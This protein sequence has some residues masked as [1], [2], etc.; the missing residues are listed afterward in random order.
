MKLER[1]RIALRLPT[2]YLE[3]LDE[4][5]R[6]H[7]Q[8]RTEVI[9]EALMHLVK[10]IQHDTYCDDFLATLRDRSSTKSN[11][12]V[13]NIRLPK[14]YLDYLKLNLYNITACVKTATK[15]YLLP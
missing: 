6:Q 15:L 5:A 1:Q 13:I 4:I 9:E 14:M 12:T 11:S 7:N 2:T 10:D 8:T 3:N